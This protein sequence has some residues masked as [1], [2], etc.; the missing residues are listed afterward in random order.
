MTRGGDEGLRV[1]F[2]WAGLIL[3]YGLVPAAFLAFWVLDLFAKSYD[4]PVLQPLAKAAQGIGS[5]LVS[6]AFAYLAVH[7]GAEET[8][9]LAR[10]VMFGAMVPALAAWAWTLDDL[11]WRWTYLAAIGGFAIVAATNPSSGRT[12]LGVGAMA[13]LIVFVAAANQLP[14]RRLARYAQALR[15][16]CGCCG[17]KQRAVHELYALGPSGES[18]IK[19]YLSGRGPWREAVAEE[20]DRCQLVGHGPGPDAR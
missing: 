17:Y 18:V 20:W 1:T 2:T 3:L 5:A 11:D 8:P 7:I 10:W 4:L 15:H 13:G 14:D 16:E 19:E 6:A 12:M 9:R